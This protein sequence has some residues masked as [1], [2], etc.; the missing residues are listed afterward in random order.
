MALDGELRHL[1]SEQIQELLDQELTPEEEASVQEH[2]AVCTRC[3]SEVD[4]W[5]LLFSNL[6]GLPELDPSPAFLQEV[7]QKA[8][9]WEPLGKRAHGWLA[10]RKT[11]RR[12]EAHIPAGS[13]QDFLE[14]LLPVQ[15]A[16][17]MEAHLASCGSCGEE[18]QEWKNLFGSFQPLGHFAPKSGFAERVMAQVLVPAPVPLPAGRWSSLPGRALVGARSLLPKTR[19][20]WAVVGGVAS[21]P[22]ITMAALIYLVFSR[23][24][25]TPG[26]F[27]S[28]VLW[29][30][31]ALVDTLVA[32]VSTGVLESAV[33]FRAYSLFEPL[34]QS[35]FLLGFG[36]LAFSLISAGSLWVLYRN[37]I[38]TPSDDRYARARV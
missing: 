29:K 28:Y 7:L 22:T 23:P 20:G 37:L 4:S 5:G 17:R 27:G 13:I 32:T 11:N 10:A 18:V 3:Q 31:S 34:T 19:H 9:V 36:G 15:P 16:G 24:L 30:A 33:L 25:L 26:T 8:P 1:V 6:A 12:E 35:P 14:N 2:L 38:V 21:A